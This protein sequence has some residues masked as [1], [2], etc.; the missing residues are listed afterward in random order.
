VT[1]YYMLIAQA[2]R[3]LDESTGWTRR[4]LYERARAT[5]LREL[6]AIRPPLAES[7][8]AKER[9]SLESAIRKVE[10]DVARKSGTKPRETRS[11]IAP[12]LP[13]AARVDSER[14]EQV[15]PRKGRAQFSGLRPLFARDLDCALEIHFLFRR[16]FAENSFLSIL[17]GA[18]GA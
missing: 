4:A 15:R 8:I 7:A 17:L 12:Q 11:D 6:R 10:T 1:D 3:D 14:S 16:A 9:L 13:R 2:V 18:C 5:Q